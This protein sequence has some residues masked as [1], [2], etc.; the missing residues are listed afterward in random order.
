MRHHVSP[1]PTD[2]EATAITAAIE[3]LWPRAQAAAPQERPNVDWRFSGRWWSESAVTR[4]TRP[5]F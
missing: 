5:G 1:V 3:V 2:D 4:R